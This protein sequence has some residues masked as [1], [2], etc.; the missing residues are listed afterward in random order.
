MSQSTRLLT[1]GLIAFLLVSTIT[2]ATTIYYYQ[3]YA[4]ANKKYNEYYQKYLLAQQNY[5]EYHQKYLSAQQNYTL[6]QQNYTSIRESVI[7]ITV[8]ID[9]GNGT[10]TTN[11]EVYLAPNTT[12]LDAL[13]AVTKV[14]ATYWSAYQSWFI[15]AIN[16]VFSN[17]KGNNRWWVFS[18]NGEHAL[19][20]ADQ[21][22]LD[23]GD[24]VEWIYYQ[25]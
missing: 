7:Q 2:T 19:M 12:V 14:N 23:D 4:S 13:K 5:T 8:K 21:Y 15:N 25:Y 24:N 6:A 9:Y 16:N 10:S 1:I 17:E 22:R 20:S 18:V 3:E 11:D